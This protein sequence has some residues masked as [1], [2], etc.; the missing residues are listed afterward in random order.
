MVWEGRSEVAILARSKENLESRTSAI[1]FL[2]C[3]TSTTP[4]S[5]L[6]RVTGRVVG[7]SGVVI[8]VLI[9]GGHASYT[10]MR[11]VL[12]HPDDTAWRLWAFHAIN[13]RIL[14]H[15]ME[16]I[17][18]LISSV[19]AIVKLVRSTYNERF[20]A[21]RRRCPDGGESAFSTRSKRGRA[22]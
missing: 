6:G 1:P 2:S 20:R 17:T 5:R 22:H 16:T 15:L 19:I 14:P 13:R 18:T 12:T 9:S 21:C 8:E 7:P 3:I 10:A 11:R 4:R